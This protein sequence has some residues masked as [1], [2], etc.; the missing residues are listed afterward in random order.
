M[1]LFNKNKI[2]VVLPRTMNMRIMYNSFNSFGLNDKPENIIG[3]NKILL[4]VAN[5]HMRS[6]LQWCEKLKKLSP[7]T[8]IMA[9]NIANP[10][11][12]VEYHK[13]GVVDY[14]R[15]G[16]GNGNGCLTTQQT[17][18]GYPTG[19]LVRECFLEKDKYKSELKIVA[20]GGVK[21]YADII[22]ALALGADYV[23]VGSLFSKAI[24]SSAP[25]YFHG[26]KISQKKAEWLYDL[27]YD[28]E[29]EFRGMSTKGAQ[30]A[31]GYKK[32]KT[33]EGVTRRFKVEYT[34]EKWVENF[35]SYL[36]SNMSYTNSK[37]LKDFIGNVDFTFISQ[38]SF[39]RFNK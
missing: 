6:V 21:K 5:G 7:N 8:E 22:K 39:N 20:D 16:I 33:S 36:R 2:G 19:S 32:F 12:F 26:F 29:K 31:L 13:S 23:M 3:A 37:T 14:V 17:G 34:L 4:D 27:G 24:E 28:I 38:N 1:F 15:V 11:T 30:E 9:G 18:V 35:E 25:N 10:K